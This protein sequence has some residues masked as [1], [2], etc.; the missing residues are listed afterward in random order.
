VNL[1][2]VAFLAPIPLVWLVRNAR[3]R[4]GF[5]LGSVFGLAYFGALLYWIL[6][7][8]VMGWTALVCV[9]AVFLG[10]F[11][12]LA[13]IVWR[14]EHPYRSAI[15]LAALWTVIEWIRAMWPLGGFAWGQLGSTQT[16]NPFLLRLASVTG[17]WGISFLVLLASALLLL[18][19]E[20]ARA[21]P[22]RAAGLAAVALAAVLL[23]GAIPVLQP[24]GRALDVAAVQVDVLKA[25]G[26]DPVARDIRVA[27]LNT[28]QQDKLFP[29]PPVLAVWGEGALN[30]GAYMD[31]A[32]MAKV[33]ASIAE[34]GVPTL[35][36][37]VTESRS[38]TERTE[39]LLFDGEGHLA[40][41]YAKV[42]LVPF[43]EYVPWR[44]ELRWI[45]AL[46]QVPVDRKPGERI[47]T[48]DVTGLPPF[49]T[50]I[51]FENSYPQI[52]RDMVREGAQFLVLTINNASY[53]YT[54]ASHQHLVM[55][56][57]RAA[58]EAR[59]VV[60]AAVSG[61]SAFVDPSGRLVAE[62]RLF[63]P[64]ILR[65]E[66]RAS[67]RETLY[68]RFG[69]WVPWLSL[70]LVVGLVATPRTR[71]RTTEPVQPLPDSPRTLV[72]LPTYDE[73]DTIRPV[74]EGLLALPDRVDVLVVDDSSPDGTGAL[75]RTMAETEPRLSLVQRPG[76]AGLASAYLLGFRRGIDHAYDLLVEMDSD[77]SHQPEE[78]AGLLA[79]AAAHDLVIGSRYVPGGSVSDWTRSRIA[80][81]KAGNLYARFMLGF[82]L[83][84]AT[85]GFRVFRRP[86]LAA[87]LTH[88]IRSDGYGFQI[89]LAL[90]AYDA[91]ASVVESPITFR[92]RRHGRSKI[93]RR[94]V[95]EALWLVTVWG[96]KG[97]LGRGP[98]ALP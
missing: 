68:A 64:G 34:V 70:L 53:E 51:C 10:V 65:H 1:G 92:E 58:E 7:F 80:L 54:A 39:A 15:G 22:R 6:L 27:Q 46:R 13:P 38:G 11:G 45:S 94:I 31:P 86:L 49:G 75:V 41:H 44:H 30:T 48:V 82:P 17:V 78:L 57:L 88:P 91:G 21:Q 81:S 93:S 87:L 62:S 2:P 55:S 85:S 71:R 69:D 76:K 25:D 20:S 28:A 74:I 47:H 60:H 98:S 84:D 35:T 26:L 67:T 14:P 90:R 33:R 96:I 52:E 19:A 24:N 16:G 59:W 29:S 12:A 9:S 3:S 66:I 5:L 43:G 4:R 8:G 56:Q 18:A 42:H 95:A 72:I 73:R 63:V 89:E 77:L 32:T 37:A 97:R 50:P 79:A 23:P 36:G 40:D 61:V 83:R